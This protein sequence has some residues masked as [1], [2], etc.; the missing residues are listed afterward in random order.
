MPLLVDR[1]FDVVGVV[2]VPR[3]LGV[4]LLLPVDV[5]L[6]GHEARLLRHPDQLV[7]AA[8]LALAEAGNLAVDDL[9]V[10][11]HELVEDQHV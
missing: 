3:L 7:H 8:V 2:L 5:L 4:L 6:A 11:G 10:R 1:V 9:A